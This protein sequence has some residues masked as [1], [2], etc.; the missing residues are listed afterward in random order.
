M[1]ILTIYIQVYVLYIQLLKFRGARE[2]VAWSFQ[3]EMEIDWDW[4]Y[5]Y[6]ETEIDWDLVYPI[7]GYAELP[8]FKV[9]VLQ[10]TIDE[11]DVACI[12]VIGQSH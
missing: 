2:S 3:A 10:G 9:K 8:K 1:Y 11:L 6:T 4:I 5:S 12:A 7:R